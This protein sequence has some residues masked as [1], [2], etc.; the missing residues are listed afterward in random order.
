MVTRLG[1]DLLSTHLLNKDNID[2]S[3]SSIAKFKAVC[4]NYGVSDIRAVGTSAIREAQDSAS[5]IERVR[6]ETGISIRILSGEE[7]ALFTLKGITGLGRKGSLL[8]VDIGGGS[9]ELILSGKEST[10]PFKFSVPVGAIKLYEKFISGDPPSPQDIDLLKGHITKKFSPALSLI[11]RDTLF[12]PGCTLVITGGT[13]TTLAAIK[14]GM[15]YYD[16]DRIQGSKLTYDDVCKIFDKLAAVPLA[17]RLKTPGIEQERGDIIL[18][19]TMIIITIMEMLSMKEMIVSD[20]GLMEGI[21]L[22]LD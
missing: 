1:K 5:F 12:K 19:G 20:Y 8:A 7:E 6:K 2:I 11:R 16:G 4:D 17:E 13:P 10:E 21:A 14:I 22:S 15:K 18:S 9:T 3:I